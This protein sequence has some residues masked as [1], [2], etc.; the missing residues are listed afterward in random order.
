MKT[1]LCQRGLTS[2]ATVI[3]SICRSGCVT[4]GGSPSFKTSD[5][6][7]P[8]PP[9]NRQDGTFQIPAGSLCLAASLF[10]IG[11]AGVLGAASFGDDFTSGL[12]PSA[13]TVLSNTPLYA[14]DVSQGDVRFSKPAGG[15]YALQIVGAAWRPRLRGDFDVQIEYRDASI[16]RADGVPGN[17][18]QLNMEFGPQVLSVV[19][20]DEWRY[21]HNA[22]VWISPPSE[23]RGTLATRATSGILRITRVGLHVRAYFNDTLLFE[24]DYNAEE[25]NL[26]FTLQNNGTLDATSVAFDNFSV[27]ADEI[28]YPPAPPPNVAPESPADLS[29]LAFPGDSIITT[30]SDAWADIPGL[31]DQVETLA[32]EN[33]EIMFSARARA[34]FGKRLYVRALLDGEPAQPSEIVLVV[35]DW[36]GTKSFT[37]VGINP[38][39]GVHTVQMQWRAETGGDGA[40]GAR[41]LTLRSAKEDAPDGSLFLSSA[42]SDPFLT[43][44]PSQGLQCL[45]DLCRSIHLQQEAALA[46]SLSAETYLIGSGTLGI[47]AELDG[48]PVSPHNVVFDRGGFRGARSF[49][50]VLKGVPAGDHSVA[51]SWGVFGQGTAGMGDRTLSID[52]SPTC[53][54]SGGLAVASA[55]S[56]VEI[57]TTSSAWVDLPDLSTAFLSAEDS[58]VEIRFSGESDASEGAGLLV[59]AL[60]DGEPA[61]PP[62]A[63]V[64]EFNQNQPV[65]RTFSFGK[66]HVEAGLHTVRLQWKADSGTAYVGD[67]TLTVLSSHP[68]RWHRFAHPDTP[69]TQWREPSYPN[70]PITVPALFR[71]TSEPF[72]LPTLVVL[73]D[74]DDK[75]PQADH[76]AQYFADMFFGENL[77]TGRPSVF[78]TWRE[79]SNGRLLITPAFLG[80]THGLPD[81]VV[82]WVHAQSQPGCCR[83]AANNPIDAASATDCAQ[84]GGTWTPGSYAYYSGF[85][86]R[87][88][89]EGIRQ[90]DPYFDYGLYD[91][92][93]D[94]LITSDELLVIVV[95]AETA[96]GGNARKTDPPFVPVE[97]GNWEVRQ[98]VTGVTEAAHTGLFA[99]EIGHQAFG[100]GDLYQ[101]EGSTR[102]ADGYLFNLQWFPPDP[103]RYSL[104]GGNNPASFLS[105]LDPWAKLHLGFLKPRVMTRN[106]VAE[107]YDMESER[108]LNDQA[109]QPE[110]IILYDPRRPDPYKEY[111][112]L[113]NRNR[114]AR[115][116]GTGAPVLA[117]GLA[118]WHITERDGPWP[119]G[120]DLRQSIRL[121]RRGD[122]WASELDSLWDGT[123][124]STGYDLTPFSSPRNTRWADESS[125]GISLEDISAA[126]PVMTFNL[127]TPG[128]GL[129]DAGL[130]AWWRMEG[131]AKDELGQVHGQLESLAGPT[132]YQ[133]GLSGEALRLDGVED[134]FSAPDH[135]SLHPRNLTIEGWFQLASPGGTQTLV[136]KPLGDFS[137]HSVVVWQEAGQLRAQACNRAGCSPILASSWSPAPDQWYHVAYTF[138]DDNDRHVLYINGVPVA[139]GSVPESIEYDGNDWVVGADRINGIPAR[140]MTGAADEISIW[141]RA[142]GA[143][144]IQLLF[145]TQ[146]HCKQPLRSQSCQPTPAGVLAW[147]AAE[148]NAR[149]QT[150]LGHGQLVDHQVPAFTPGMVGQGFALSGAAGDYVMIPDS[151]ALRP[152]GLTVEGWVRFDGLGGL[153]QTIMAKP[154]GNA[155]DDS[156]V[157]WHEAGALRGR[158][159]DGSGCSASLVFPWN[160]TPGQWYHVAYIADPSAGV[161][162][163]YLDGAVAASA[164]M[165][166]AIGY[167]ANPWLIGADDAS[168][169]ATNFFSGTIDELALYNRPLD[170]SEIQRIFQ[171]GALGKC[172]REVVTPA[173]IISA[174][175]VNGTAVISWTPDEPGWIL[176]ESMTLIPSAWVNAPSGGANPVTVST[177]PKARFYRLIRP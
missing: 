39:P 60:I 128:G 76:T 132:S 91:R 110:A 139:G 55:G 48:Q 109:S 171:A 82:G 146:G 115:A 43:T 49:T 158:V 145:T 12:E 66:D 173:L 20:S 116:N 104:M 125:S 15:Q 143:E 98:L 126:G 69:H 24:G 103:A 18:V 153:R 166:H 83:N 133:P 72:V 25:A 107:L 136:S 89:A 97:G 144:E 119:D 142:L 169:A 131:D 135:F 163:L 35:N 64:G 3:E 93:R 1:I 33:L 10:L 123:D 36:D 102:V 117:R 37:F 59:R 151:P 73:L 138:D 57:S 53:T 78:E 134:Y 94:G 19:R 51:I 71:D 176:Q 22:H 40:L 9:A 61:D 23:W 63:V 162:A 74:F 155:S 174:G 7:K 87:K 113:E 156:V 81:G 111:F 16:E 150:G 167:D 75:A 80:E 118:V 62:Q 56:G 160:P 29:V 70:L 2:A 92:N 42:M 65:S 86:E 141:D 129:N 67:R 159:C 34:A 68:R 11:H 148:G 26:S 58:A 8:V 46:I 27:D 122:F 100:L 106:G 5:V 154:V 168:G 175:A 79:N 127:L 14:I 38:A 30:T 41:T 112:I 157:V 4:R 52:A 149:S 99:H 50:F 170:T 164:A 54:P 140:Y 45:P 121:I 90:A 130:I 13:W 152:A 137:N 21:G 161:H 77:S 108:P 31:R 28:I 17:Q 101:H 147:W 44:D 172:G 177:P 32:G 88:R 84:K 6:S 105:H 165:T 95:N 114:P 47:Y 96:F 85:I 124:L 120:I